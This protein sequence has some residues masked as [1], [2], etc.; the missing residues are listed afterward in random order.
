MANSLDKYY[1][2][3]AGL[4]TRSNKLL[5]PPGSFRRGS[6]N[7]RYDFQDQ[8]T[9]A[10]G[11]QHKDS[12]APT[13]V[14]IFEYKFRNVDTGAAETQ[15]LGVATNGNLY[16]KL[17]STLS[18]ASHGAATS[19]SIYYDEVADSFKCDLAGLG[20]VTITDTMV[21]RDDITT[22]NSLYHALNALAGVAVTISGSYTVK[23]YLLNCVIN[24]NTFADNVAFY[25][26]IVPFPDSTSVPFV[27]TRDYNTSSDYEGIS[28]VNLNNVIYITDGG[29]PMKYDGASVY[30]AGVPAV[31]RFRENNLSLSLSPIALA[32]TVTTN[33]SLPAGTYG[34][35]FRYGFKD[36]NGAVY[37]GKSSTDIGFL[38]TVTISVPPNDAAGVAF[39][40]YDFGKDFPVNGCKVSSYNSSTKTITTVGAHNVKAGMAIVQPVWSSTASERSTEVFLYYYYAKVNSVTSSTIVLDSVDTE[41]VS[42]SAT[43]GGTGAEGAVAFGGFTTLVANRN[44]T[45]LTINS[46]ATVDLNGFT[47]YYT[48]TL[49]NNG[50]IINSVF[51]YPIA[52]Q[53][54]NAAW[55]PTTMY[56]QI[57]S[58]LVDGEPPYGSFGEIYR[59]KVDT[60]SVGPW[61][62]AGFGP[63][64]ISTAY[65][66][67]FDLPVIDNLPDTALFL[68]FD[69]Q[70]PGEE[71]PRACKYLTQWQN[72]LVQA[73]RPADTSMIGDFY[74]SITSE[75][76][77]AFDPI[78]EA[79]SYYFKITEANLCDFQSVYWADTLAPEGFPQ[80]G[81]NEFSIDT[82]FADRVTGIAPN[83]D[84]LF[85]LKERSTAVLSG[86]LGTN[87]IVMEVLEADSGCISHKTIEEVRGSLVW[88]D[89]INGFYS[90]VAGRLPENIG[91]PI[92]DY[93]KI[94]EGKLNFR[95][96]SAANFRKESLYVC[97]VGTTTFVFD[98]ADDGSLKR[99]CWYLWDRIDGKSVL[100]TSDDKL[101]IWDGSKTWKMKLTNSRYDFTDHKSAIPWVVN[102]SWST[103]GFPTVD[104][105]YVN[106]WINS[107]QGDFT[108]TVKQYGNFLEDQVA[109]QTN[110]Q[111]IAE[112]S[113]KKAIKEPVKA[114]L[115]KLSAISFGMENAEKNKWV[116][117]QGYEIQYSP[118]YSTGEPKR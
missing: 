100:A 79:F 36:Y 5:Q 105:H 19:V 30:R 67:P 82:K 116:R 108:L 95:T 84:S 57:Q 88:L 103:Q 15:I 77:T 106:L 86:D 37:Y 14:D 33:T 63:I 49:T 31:V 78:F 85:A 73:G 24:D 39:G 101:L 40:G 21:L 104:K 91:F 48:G 110:V 90:C 45:N 20:S 4:D 76:A 9:Q 69:D 18:F 50:T 3:Y 99:D 97:S 51:N 98:Y 111:F 74:P 93:T 66:A 70:E 47:L 28:S 65:S 62:L 59:T 38:D 113:A 80:S 102:T 29:F 96:A 7:F 117:I 44:I 1:N 56:G 27:T 83:K 23:A 34:Y 13:F 55:V 81:A 17:N 112:T 72:Q 32:P 46:G 75:F 25:W 114:Y 12:G 10:N 94:N 107:I 52:N 68:N 35:K 58:P 60:Q 61:Y 41:T 54:L 109:S 64:P 43:V 92:Q 6:K 89:G 118:D 8:I 115:P 42:A 87:D 16:R 53:I 71:I 2:V 11:F 26:E 22:A